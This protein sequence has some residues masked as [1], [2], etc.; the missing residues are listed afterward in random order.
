MHRV[1]IPSRGGS[2]RRDMIEDDNMT[3]GAFINQFTC[4][5]ME[6]VRKTTFGTRRLA[7]LNCDK[8]RKTG[9]VTRRD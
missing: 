6:S 5:Q 3:K 1:V 8:A 2:V 7:V 9:G 4:I